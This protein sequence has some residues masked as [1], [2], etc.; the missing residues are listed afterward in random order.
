MKL[1][2]T[3]IHTSG[4]R[5]HF[6][7]YARDRYGEVVPFAKTKDGDSR[8]GNATWDLRCDG[9]RRRQ[10]P[11][12]HQKASSS[13]SSSF[14]EKIEHCGHAVSAKSAARRRRI[15]SS[16]T[17][18]ARIARASKTIKLVWIPVK[19]H[20]MDADF[21]VCVRLSTFGTTW[22]PRDRQRQA[23]ACIPFVGSSAKSWDL[24]RIA[25]K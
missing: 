16:W 23:L 18:H 21:R 22:P 12:S 2:T 8:V 4:D 20:L 14:V 19:S 9:K 6:D 7:R 17:P 24:Q 13:S 11:Y 10:R 3:G 25:Y 5:T 15:V 1:Q